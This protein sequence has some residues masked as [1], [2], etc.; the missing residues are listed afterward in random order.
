M[1]DFID[2]QY[3][4]HFIC[5][6][7]SFFTLVRLESK[8]VYLSSHR[9]LQIITAIIT[10]F[11]FYIV[12]M[13]FAR[14]AESAELL[15]MLCDTCALVIMYMM[16]LYLL[17]IKDPKYKQII[18]TIAL[19]IMIAICFFDFGVYR[20]DW[21]LSFNVD[22]IAAL[23]IFLASIFLG[24]FSHSRN[25]FDRQDE[26]NSKIMLTAFVVTIIGY[27]LQ[28]YVFYLTWI[29]S[30]AYLI[31]CLIFYW[32]ASTN[33]IEDTASILKGTL[34]NRLEHPIGL[35]NSDFYVIDCNDSCRALFGKAQNVEFAF[36]GGNYKNVFTLGKAMVTGHENDKDFLAGGR[37][38]RVHWTSEYLNGGG[39]G[40]IF[41]ATDI[42]DQYHQMEQAKKDSVVKNKYLTHLAHELRNP[43]HA[44]M[45]IGDMLLEKKDI[46]SKNKSFIGHIKKTSDDLLEFIDSTIDYSRIESGDF[47]FNDR[48][49]DVIAFLEDL[50]YS[51]MV[52]LMTR[53]IDFSI[54]ILTPVPHRLYGDEIRIRE[55]FQ[56]LLGNAIKYTQ[57]G[58]V[59]LELGFSR[60]NGR[61][62]VSFAVVDTGGGMTASQARE[63]F[64]EMSLEEDNGISDGA[65]FGL[66]ITRSLVMRMDGHICA[67]SDGEKDS[68]IYGDFYQKAVETDMLPKQIINRRSIVSKRENGTYLFGGEYIY[69][70]ARILVADDLKINLEIMRQILS[71]WK[72]NVNFVS[73]G[74]SAL[75]AAGHAQFDLIILDQRMAPMNG[76][77]CCREL[78]K[79][80]DAPIILVTANEM[81]DIEEIVQKNG[82][83]D[84]IVKPVHGAQIKAI[85]EK[86]LPKEKAIEFDESI[87]DM[88]MGDREHTVIYKEMLET[89]IREMEP[90]IL[91]LPTYRKNDPELFTVKVHGINGVCQQIGRVELAEKAL[92]MEMA[93]ESDT[94]YYVDS[95]LNDF[96]DEICDVVE[97]VTMELTQINASLR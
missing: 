54:D 13:P 15:Y 78:K 48:E 71:P 17:F 26:I 60:E 67:E 90:I 79:I 53:P 46:S 8:D 41:M 10:I 34:Y 82:F 12:I 93:A 87:S 21:A 55:V 5:M 51:N 2:A 43:L 69:P 23:F 88:V 63:I 38:Y 19:T 94:W 29:R 95:H 74:I 32:M 83:A 70:D 81:N 28:G 35:V 9:F 86:Y 66:A 31:D 92:I 61:Y 24:I 7:V 30:L 20:F 76:I 6:T 18:V 3:I 59:R 62:R 97:D 75:K 47:A 4:F 37:W 96:L 25:F 44:I 65:G 33:K 1:F 27:T 14:D 58:S 36:E 49:Y 80:T 50:A 42:T 64:K 68:R 56:N 45:G 84:Y 73:D 57:S 72:C 39:R 11:N 52:N 40:Y 85:I 91:N 22:M 77:E 89:F 16:F